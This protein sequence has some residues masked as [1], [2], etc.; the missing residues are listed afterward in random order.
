MCKPHVINCRW[1]GSKPLESNTAYVQ[2][3]LSLNKAL[4]T[5]N[6]AWAPSRRSEHPFAQARNA[7]SSGVASDQHGLFNAGRRAVCFA[8][9]GCLDAALARSM[10]Q[11]TA[12][13][14]AISLQLHAASSRAGVRQRS[15]RAVATH[16]RFRGE[17]VRSGPIPGRRRNHDLAT[18]SPNR[19]AGP[20]RKTTAF[21]GAGPGGGSGQR[22][23]GR[24]SRSSRRR[25]PRAA[26]RGPA[27][28]LFSRAAA[29]RS[30]VS[31]AS[32]SA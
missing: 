24:V 14:V 30:P 22:S 26:L 32:A 6:E 31:S 3:A 4:S 19:P 13:F 12:A 9:E 25:G 18:R 5:E 16:E 28:P 27:R 20:S 23:G 1:F 7:S 11:S 10:A 2:T 29:P 17:V 15:P 8:R 21:Q